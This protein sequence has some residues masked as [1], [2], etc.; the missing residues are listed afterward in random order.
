MFKV[1]KALFLDAAKGILWTILFQRMFGTI[2]PQ[3]KEF[4][5][6]SYP[7]CD[8]PEL[9]DLIDTKLRRICNSL[10]NYFEISSLSSDS[11]YESLDIEGSLTYNNENNNPSGSEINNNSSNNVSGF[12]S[13]QEEEQEEHQKI[14]QYSIIIKFFEPQNISSQQRQPRQPQ[15]KQNTAGNDITTL[16]TPYKN[17]E[18][19]TSK[20]PKLKLIPK[21]PYSLTT[22]ATN[23]R[24]MSP[25]HETTHPEPSSYSK[26]WES[27]TINFQISD[28]KITDDDDD[29][30]NRHNKTEY[31]NV[32][33][34]QFKSV[35]FRIV[36]YST[37]ELDSIPPIYSTSYA[38][39]PFDIIVVSNN[40]R[41]RTKSHETHS[42]QKQNIIKN[43]IS[44]WGFYLKRLFPEH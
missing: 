44:D 7:W 41:H 31:L 19:Y 22:P 36:Q 21:F 1:D 23:N 4:L 9:N 25:I 34:S 35:L 40:P 12:N 29:E 37:V 5:E 42:K 10:E 6:V 39:H 3:T 16:I 28:H 33:R 38:P 20:T 8:L 30:S 13:S 32:V 27:W 11:S 24:P 2:F 26:Y 18:P 43:N 17:R 15:Q 14:R